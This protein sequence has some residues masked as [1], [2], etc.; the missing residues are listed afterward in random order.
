MRKPFVKTQGLTLDEFANFFHLPLWEFYQFDR[1]ADVVSG[2]SLPRER[3]QPTECDDI[4][5]QYHEF[6]GEFNRYAVTDCIRRAEKQLVSYL[7]FYPFDAYIEHEEHEYRERDNSSVR[8]HNLYYSKFNRQYPYWSNYGRAFCNRYMQYTFNTDFPIGRVGLR[9]ESDL[10]LDIEPVLYATV[11]NSTVMDGFYIDVPIELGTDINDINIYYGTGVVGADSRSDWSITPLKRALASDGLSVRLYGMVYQIVR[12]E[13]LVGWEI[14][15]LTISETDTYIDSI[16]AT[17]YTY[18]A[19][20][21]VRF[22]WP[23]HCEQEYQQGCA[24]VIDYTGGLILPIPTMYNEEDECVLTNLNTGCHISAPPFVQVSYQTRSNI[25]AHYQS[26]L[27]E[28]IAYL[29]ASC[30]DCFPCQ[31]GCAGGERELSKY[32]KPPVHGE[33]FITQYEKVQSNPFG[34]TLGGLRAYQIV[35]ELKRYTPLEL[36]G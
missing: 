12:P 7:G 36:S 16:D 18:N 14:G 4:V 5:Y 28:A 29:A 31:C 26:K 30:L 27:K 23:H 24:T 1:I 33:N 6:R 34:G 17:L 20:E 35:L 8:D 22:R 25:K 21:A 19:C 9:T 32:G 10:E 3:I 2:G 15:P 13:L 11:P